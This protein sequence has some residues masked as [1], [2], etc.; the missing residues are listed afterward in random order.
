MSGEWRTSAVF[1]GS[2]REKEKGSDTIAR[3][4]SGLMG[5]KQERPGNPDGI[6]KIERSNGHIGA[7]V[8][9]LKQT[10]PRVDHRAATYPSP[11]LTAAS[12]SHD[13]SVYP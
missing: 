4:S 2:K 9:S 1:T 6:V 3:E 7:A 5:E 13:P 12:F 11:W 10:V 8:E